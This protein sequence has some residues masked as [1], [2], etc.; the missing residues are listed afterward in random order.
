MPPRLP[1]Y[2]PHHHTHTTHAIDKAIGDEY[3]TPVIARAGGD[4][5]QLRGIPV[6]TRGVGSTQPGTHP[7][8][9][10]LDKHRNQST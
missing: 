3:E 1:R 9:A 2:D 4:H 6:T 8:G 10:L 5:K 7:L